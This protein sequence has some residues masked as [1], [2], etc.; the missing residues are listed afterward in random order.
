MVKQYDDDDDDGLTTFDH[1][2][3]GSDNP[4]WSSSVLHFWIQN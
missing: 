3:D 1:D 4:A 2:K